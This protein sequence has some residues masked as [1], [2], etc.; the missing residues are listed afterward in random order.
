M[1]ALLV[2]KG[3]SQG[4]LTYEELNE[5]LPD[6]AIAPDRLDALMQQF[7]ELGIELLDETEANKHAPAPSPDEPDEA[8]MRAAEAEIENL[9]ED[10]VVEVGSKRIDDPVRMYLTQMGE[11]PLLTRTNEEIRLAKKIE[12]T[13]M[14]FRRKVMESDYCLQSAVEILAQVAS[15][16]L[17]FDR[18]MRISTAE[19]D[20]KGTISKRIPENL[21]TVRKL[22][23]QNRVDWEKHVD[24][25]TSGEPLVRRYPIA[26]GTGGA[27]R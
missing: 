14:A 20:A 25:S 2:S 19:V 17:P 13:R 18:T 3:K 26:C 21:A 12:L 8:M 7:D 22:L 4:Y 6:D 16:E 27:R 5:L 9:K 23:E 24:D 15:G 10:D 1:G 11:I